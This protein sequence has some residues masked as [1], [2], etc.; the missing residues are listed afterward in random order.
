[1]ADFLA[2]TAS[3]GPRVK[4][5]E[6]VETILARYWLDPGF[7]VGVSYD[8]DTGEAYLFMYGFIW[9]EAWQLP[10]GTT[11]F[12]FNP[13]AEDDYP[14]GADGF[15]EL[16]QELAPH[17]QEATTIQAIGATKCSFPLSACEWHLEAGGKTVKLNEFRQ[18]H[19]EIVAS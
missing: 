3:N 10:E 13:F 2:T 1:M 19:L 17:L 9:P 11:A 6:A 12:E 8:H 14:G 5:V 4:N 7:N 16:L 18:G 15:I